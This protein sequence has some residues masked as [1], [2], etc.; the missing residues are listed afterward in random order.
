MEWINGGVTPGGNRHI[1]CSECDTRILIYGGGVEEFEEIEL[2]DTC[3][4]CRCKFGGATLHEMFE[5]FLQEE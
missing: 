2:P 5:E 4:E 3:P 1:I